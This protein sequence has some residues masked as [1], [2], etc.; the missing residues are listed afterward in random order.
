MENGKLIIDIRDEDLVEMLRMKADGLDASD[1]MLGK[2]EKYLI[3]IS[4]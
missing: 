1:Y 4:K 2:L 3:S